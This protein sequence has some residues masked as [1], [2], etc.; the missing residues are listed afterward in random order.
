MNDDALLD[1]RV[2]RALQSLPVPDDARTATVLEDVSSRRRPVGEPWHL[3]L[4]AAVV[5]AVLVLAP[6]L[7]RSMV[8]DPRPAPA[9]HPGSELVGT[10]SRVLDAAQAPE[11]DGRW[12]IGFEDR[13][14][15]SLTPPATIGAGTDGAAYDVSGAQL[16]VDAFV[17]G[18]C[19]ELPP[20]TYSWSLSDEGLRLTPLEDA[21]AQRAALFSGTWREVR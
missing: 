2:R 1:A 16:R 8:D 13:G 19:N 17:N 11:W 3:V 15:L 14:V 5:V 18:V 9:R 4:A 12:T 7:L 21:C 10:W 6:V 20:G